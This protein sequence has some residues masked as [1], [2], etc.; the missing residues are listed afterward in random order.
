MFL[1]RVPAGK[2][3]RC[4]DGRIIFDLESLKDALGEMSDHT[5]AYHY[6]VARKDFCQWVRDVIWDEQLARSL[7]GAVNRE[8][9]AEI[10]AERFDYLVELA[11]AGR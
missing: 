11:N 1:R 6:N 8:K 10:V 3:F 4:S 2:E 7:A 5:F 9:A